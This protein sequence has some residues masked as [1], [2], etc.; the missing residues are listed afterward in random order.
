MVSLKIGIYNVNKESRTYEGQENTHGSTRLVFE[1]L[2]QSASAV[3]AQYESAHA[4]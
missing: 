3:E 1:H 4:W 2:R